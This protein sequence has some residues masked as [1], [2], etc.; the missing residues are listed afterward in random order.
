MKQGNSKEQITVRQLRKHLR[1][2]KDATIEWLR[3]NKAQTEGLPEKIKHRIEVL[4]SK[5]PSDNADSIDDLSKTLE[6]AA[7]EESNSDAETESSSDQPA[8]S[9]S[10]NN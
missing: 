5:H 6:S 8:V 4:L 9:S 10:D 7:N 2:D 1:E 3:N